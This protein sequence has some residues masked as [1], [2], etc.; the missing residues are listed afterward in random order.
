MPAK[1]AAQGL[2]GGEAEDDRGEGTADG[3]GGGGD[4]GDPQRQNYN[5]AHC[6]EAD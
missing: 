1:K 6:E 2:L 4:A 3:E 5:R